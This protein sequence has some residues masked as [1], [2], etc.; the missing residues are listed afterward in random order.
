MGMVV[1]A[2]TDQSKADITTGQAVRLI[3]VNPGMG[4]NVSYLVLDESSLFQAPVIFAWHYNGKINPSS[5]TNWSG[6]DLFEGIQS[7]LLGSANQISVTSLTNSYGTNP[8]S[9]ELILGF[10]FAGSSSTLVDPSGTNVWT[11]WIKGGGE[12][13]PYGD[14]GEFTFNASPTNWVISPNT[15]DSRWIS[16]GSYDGWTICGFS[17]NGATNDTHYFRDVNEILQPVTF[18]TYYGSEPLTLTALPIPVVSTPTPAEQSISFPRLSP[19]AYGAALISLA[20]TAGSGLGVT[21]TSSKT[22]VARII[23]DTQVQVTGV[24]TTTITATQEGNASWK[25]AP[26]I[27]QTLVVGKGVPIIS[28]VP[29][30]Q[31]PFLRDQRIQLAAYSKV[32]LPI[33]FSSSKPAVISVAGATGINGPTLVIHSR[34]KAI[35]TASQRGNALWKPSSVSQVITVQ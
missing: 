27:K 22:K 3:D 26:A 13:V 1:L 21:Y 7:S 8:Y 18:G 30:P 34:G 4:A 14:N 17:Y 11:Y 24:G 23:N 5:G 33:T 10:S 16:N 12:Y 19:V 29:S 31:V 35:I 9:Q 28:F 25:P 20:A 15:S 32:D 2:L 6:T